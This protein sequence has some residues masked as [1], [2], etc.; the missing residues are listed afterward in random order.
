MLPP[1]TKDIA[2]IDSSIHWNSVWFCHFCPSMVRKCATAMRQWRQCRVWYDVSCAHPAQVLHRY[3]GTQ[4]NRK[5]LL[6][7]CHVLSTVFCLA[8]DTDLDIINQPFSL[9]LKFWRSGVC[10]D[11]CLPRA[12]SFLICHVWRSVF[13]ITVSAHFYV[14]KCPLLAGDAQS[15]LIYDKI[16]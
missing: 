10:P 3:A 6:M 8:F 12:T 15:C 9:K 2:D 5:P 16:C 11:W 13:P 7:L 1:N 14:Y 4:E